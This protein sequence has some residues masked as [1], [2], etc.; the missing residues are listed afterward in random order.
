MNANEIREW[1]IKNDIFVLYNIS[2]LENESI[3]MLLGCSRDDNDLTLTYRVENKDLIQLDMDK[4]METIKCKLDERRINDKDYNVKGRL[5]NDDLELSLEAI[6][7]SNQNI[8]H[9]I[10]KDKVFYNKWRPF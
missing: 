2:N 4:Y 9:V 1:M 6:K 3:V 10:F 7:I 5:I 8:K